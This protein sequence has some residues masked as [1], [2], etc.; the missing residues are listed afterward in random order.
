MPP[1]PRDI[2][3]H[4]AVAGFCRLGGIERT[5]KGSHRVVKMPNGANLAIPAGIVK[6]GLLKHLIKIAHLTE[7]QFLDAV[8]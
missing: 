5:G 7:G 2:R 4:R 3:Q 8:N 6:V 1:F